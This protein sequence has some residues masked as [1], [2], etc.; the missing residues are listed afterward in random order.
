MYIN[1]LLDS[2]LFKMETR[3]FLNPGVFYVFFFL[4]KVVDAMRQ[5]VTNM[6]GTLPPQFFAVTVTTVCCRNHFIFNSVISLFIGNGKV[7][8]MSIF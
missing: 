1:T 4:L 7:C 8:E 6:I 3:G 2:S 5:T